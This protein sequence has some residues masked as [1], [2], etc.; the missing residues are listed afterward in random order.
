VVEAGLTPTHLDWYCLA[1]GGRDDHLDLTVALAGEYG[2]AVRVG[3][4]PGRQKLR[5]RPG[6]A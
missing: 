1:D 2:L 4:E 5:R 3:L 6:A